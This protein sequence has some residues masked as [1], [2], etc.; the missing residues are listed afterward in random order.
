MY[1]LCKQK[2]AHFPNLDEVVQ[3]MVENGD[4][5]VLKHLDTV[6]RNANYGSHVAT[7]EYLDAISLWVQQG[8][9]RSL[10]EAAFYSILADESTD[11]ATI[12]E[13]SIC[14][15]WVNS[16]GLP[17]EHFLGLDSL[18][19]CDAASIF[20][21]LKAFLADHIDAGKLR[22][23]GYDGAA[24]FSCTKNGVQMRI[25]TLAPRTL[26]VPCMAHVLQ[27]CCVSASRC[28]PSLKKVFGTLMSVWKMF[29]YSPKRF[30][31]LKEM[32]TLV[33]H[34]QLKMIKPS[35]TLWLAH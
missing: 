5:E 16:S 35:D 7:S 2:I 26:F 25:R 27:I 17:V 3:L 12:E 32:Q 28:L 4:D 33:N 6:P 29:H 21:A 14:F 31:A 10:K 30:S 24:T 20:A 34:P 11:I 19:A 9:L 18:S 23:Q 22:G 13:F 8:I 1:L 15:R